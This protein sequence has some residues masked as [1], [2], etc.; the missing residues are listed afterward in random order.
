VHKAAKGA[1]TSTLLGSAYTSV[2]LGDTAYAAASGDRQYSGGHTP[3][4]ESGQHS[5]GHTAAPEGGEY[6]GG[7]TAASEGEGYRGELSVTL[8]PSRP[9]V[10]GGVVPRG[11]RQA[12]HDS[13]VQEVKAFVT[14]NVSFYFSVYI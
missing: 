1:V 2:P 4:S 14:F 8:Q 13:D 10:A 3:A 12:T 5:G 7:H 6:S 9:G 11:I